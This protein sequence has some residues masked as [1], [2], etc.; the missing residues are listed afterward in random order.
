VI[1]NS[2]IKQGYGRL[3]F[4]DGSYYEGFWE[5][6]KSEGRGVFKIADNKNPET[7]IED[8]VVI[9]EWVKDQANGL[10]MFKSETKGVRFKGL[11]QDDL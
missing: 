5:E 2:T 1:K 4:P 9:G 3:N 8:E 10:A 11:L 6:G 7:H